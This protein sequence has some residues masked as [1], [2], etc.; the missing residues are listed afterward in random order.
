M[1]SNLHRSITRSI[2]FLLTLSEKFC[3]QNLITSIKNINWTR[4]SSKSNKLRRVNTVDH[5]I[6]EVIVN[7]Q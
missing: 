2:K 3:C 6:K 4:H 1:A 5:A 7:V